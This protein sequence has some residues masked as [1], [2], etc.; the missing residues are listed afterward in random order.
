M[1]LFIIIAKKQ[2]NGN[3]NTAKK[4][5]ITYKICKMDILF[6]V[7]TMDRACADHFI[8][9]VLRDRSDTDELLR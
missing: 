3:M 1:F 8:C 7:M 2:Q 9:P 6:L 5:I 4:S